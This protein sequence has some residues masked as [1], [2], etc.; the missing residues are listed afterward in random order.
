MAKW[1][2]R[3][4]KLARRRPDGTFLPWPGGRT[5]ASLPK[6]EQTFHGI[7]VHLSAAFEA[8]HGR[9]PRVGDVHRTRK[10]DGT[11]HEL[12]WWYIKTRHGW[13]KSPTGTRRPSA[14]VVRQVMFS[15]RPGRPGRAGPG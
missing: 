5:K 9:P 1:N 2:A 10:R 6:K 4:A 12:A 7:A 11:Y 3:R 8:E 14:A 15:S 13:R